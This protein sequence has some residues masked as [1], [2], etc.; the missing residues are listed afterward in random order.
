MSLL[1]PGVPILAPII[2]QI[3][4]PI[5]FLVRNIGGFIAD[6]TVRESHTDELAITE[7]PVEQGAAITDHSYK[8]PARVTIEAA[9]SN[10]SLQAGGN[11][12]YVT[13][14]YNLFL[15]M[16]ANRSP[17][18]IITGKRIYT[19]MLAIRVGVVTDERTENALFMNVECQ[20]ILI[21]QTQV[22]T[23]G[24]ASNMQSPQLNSGLSLLGSKLLGPAN[25]PFWNGSAAASL[26]P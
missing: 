9:W 2:G 18:S 12:L 4:N 7:H 25:P 8:R 15:L 20:Q 13:E 16:Q 19:N 24:D 17:F 3:I 6:V 14:I 26:F 10:S 1:P 21:A 22:V 11:P 5:L 23:V